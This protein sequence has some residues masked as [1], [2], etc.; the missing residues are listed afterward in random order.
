MHEIILI[1]FFIMLA[2]SFVLLIGFITKKKTKVSTGTTS[3][4]ISDVF[5]RE[6]KSGY[7][8]KVPA[9]LPSCMDVKEDHHEAFSS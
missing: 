7:V 4:K 9:Q 8:L 3:R 1:C 2:H 6:V 5:L